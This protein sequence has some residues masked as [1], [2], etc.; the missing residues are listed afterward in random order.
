MIIIMW[1][2]IS[3]VSRKCEMWIHVSEDGN[4]DDDDAGKPRDDYL[5]RTQSI[6]T[7][8]ENREIRS[9]FKGLLYMH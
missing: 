1:R 3:S 5:A 6:N 8:R 9:K 7:A 4:E 2:E